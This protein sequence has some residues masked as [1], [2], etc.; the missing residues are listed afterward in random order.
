MREQRARVGVAELNRHGLDMRAH[1]IDDNRSDQFHVTRRVFLQVGDLLRRQFCRF[2]RYLLHLPLVLTLHIDFVLL[3]VFLFNRGVVHGGVC[4]QQSLWCFD[5]HTLHVFDLL[6]FRLG[7]GFDTCENLAHEQGAKCSHCCSKVP[8]VTPSHS[9]C[10]L[11]LSR[12]N[13]ACCLVLK[14]SERGFGLTPCAPLDVSFRFCFV[15]TENADYAARYCC[16]TLPLLAKAWS[17]SSHPLVFLWNTV[18]DACTLC[19]CPRSWSLEWHMLTM[20]DMANKSA[21]I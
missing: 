6:G 3:G 19:F 9:N 14:T 10:S 1:Q 11:P 7:V 8:L 2:L 4:R 20:R 5:S 18:I 13:V 21:N 15:F 12:H 17:A 16:L